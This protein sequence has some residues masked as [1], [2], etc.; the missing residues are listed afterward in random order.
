VSQATVSLVLSNSP[1]LTLTPETRQAVLDSAARLAYTPDPVARRLALGRNDLLGLHSFAPKFPIS[2][3]DSYYPYL[4]GVEQEAAT[5]G[6]DLVLF[7]GV[8]AKQSREISTSRLRLAD[9]SVLVGRNP[10]EADLRALI[11]SGYPLVYIG[12]HEEIEGLSYVGA[13]YAS[14]TQELVLRLHAAGHRT[15]LHLQ[16]VDTATASVDRER[17][18]AAAIAQLRDATGIATRVEGASITND[19]LQNWISDVGVT[20]IVLEGG[21]ESSDA[22]D[23]VLEAVTELGISVPGD[24]SIATTGL[25][26]V[27]A[28][29]GMVFSGFQV[30]RQEMGRNA[31]RLLVRLLRAEDPPPEERRQLLECAPIV[32]NTI[33]PVRERTR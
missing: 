18:F 26:Y 29:R 11:D 1:G 12:R 5:Q 33:G 2:L 10:A 22:V 20:A 15:I 19:D 3:R 17:G 6:F 31:V 14:A 9:G 32:G 13:D 7:T 21:A 28:P 30:P 16:G 4:E 24:L 8:E 25:D 27:P 23:S